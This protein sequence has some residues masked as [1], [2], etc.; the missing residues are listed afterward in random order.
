MRFT[1]R[2]LIAQ[3]G[4]AAVITTGLGIGAVGTLHVRAAVQDLSKQI[5][6]AEGAYANA[7]VHDY[8]ASARHFLDLN[9]RLLANGTLSTDFEALG[10]YFVGVI[11]ANP[12]LSTSGFGNPLGEA[13]WATQDV[14]GSVTVHMYVDHATGSP[15]HRTYR[16]ASDDS[17]ELTEEEPTTYDA[18]ERPWFKKAMTKDEPSW[19]DPFILVPENIPGVTMTQRVYGL[20]GQLV[21]VPFVDFDLRFLSRALQ[22]LSETRRGVE[23]VIFDSAGR[24]LAHSDPD[25]T[26][27]TDSQGRVQIVSLAGHRSPLIRLLA[28]ELA[29]PEQLPDEI[30]TVRAVSSDGEEHMVALHRADGV[31][32]EGRLDWH[33]AV[34]VPKSVILAGVQRQAWTSA[35]VGLAVFLLTLVA[36]VLI[37]RRLSRGF[38]WYYRSM[39]RLEDLD[40]SDTH[41]IPTR[42]LEI[43]RLG[44][45]L[46]TLRRS[47]RSFERYVP[48]SLVR[49]LMKRG[50]EAR[51]G[52][53]DQEVTILFTDT[54]GFTT[55]SEALD[56]QTLAESLSANLDVAT[57]AISRHQGTID[58][59]IG[60]SVMA[61]WNA[62]SPV[63]NHPAMACRAALDIQ[64][65]IA[66]H[67]ESTTPLW[68][69]RIG[70]NTCVAL[71]GN[72]GSTERLDYT[73][74]GD[75]VNL[76]SRIEGINKDY[77]TRIL[78]GERTRD[79]VHEVMLTRPVDRVVVKG[80]SR[81]ETLYELICE[82]PTASKAQTALAEATDRAFGHFLAERWEDAAEAYGD[83]LE[84]RPDDPVAAVLRNRCREALD[85][86]P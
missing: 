22:D 85:G 81:A 51:P 71:V 79:A 44:N 21:G 77:G 38:Y 64:R 11:R 42:I 33:V 8:S 39:A 2:A 50:I 5:Y 86:S 74:I 82:R 75:G 23:S 9:S 76:A 72:L 26:S 6:G 41:R 46:D 15:L 14:D 25:S 36:A 47:L 62:P 53:D 13:V 34:L 48:A 83:C 37:S 40:L 32:R 1:L 57:Q 54:E 68:P 29:L 65:Q 20:D 28:T 27:S 61:F 31:D 17:L 4:A 84:I 70:V 80:Q 60:D 35:A 56:P 69:I 18:R 43:H 63:P 78:L 3:L 19:T 45:Q 73:V 58:K 16:A 12:R 66:D 24:V 55:L 30:T 67:R 10:E 59:Y 49:D 52:G 7:R